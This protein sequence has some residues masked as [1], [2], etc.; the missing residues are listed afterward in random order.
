MRL[1]ACSSCHTQYDVSDVVAKSFP[2]RCGETLENVSHESVDAAIHRCG[3][4]GAG[5]TPQA[6]NCE[7]C[8]SAIVPDPGNLSL[9]CPECY[10]RCAED[11]R[12]CTAC[13][14]GF[15]P[16][17]VNVEGTELPCPGCGRLMPPRSVGGVDVNEC[18]NCNGL[19]VP[20]E[21]FDLLVSRAIEARRDAQAEGAVS[22]PRVRGSNPAAQGVK[23][24]KCPQCEA[25]MQRRNFRRSSGVIV[26]VCHQHGTWLDADELEQIAGF[27]LS[28]GTPSPTLVEEDR[29]VARATK[30]LAL[31]RI[32]SG[33]S[34]R[35]R[36][37]SDFGERGLV[38]SVVDL[39][40]ALLK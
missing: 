34:T 8:G 37:F 18:P 22:V 2:C 27:V 19:W 11:A 28:G 29:S 40:S 25:F 33:G 26:D 13:G 1:V 20:G 36:D 24:R 21:S 12:F 4:C 6:E 32:R 15:R 31:E 9:I 39:L 38:H 35:S 10:A 23:Y 16:E 30:A 17:S 7:F 3:S 14:V 5:V